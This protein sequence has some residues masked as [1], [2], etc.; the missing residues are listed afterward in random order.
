MWNDYLT[1]YSTW[2]G[3]V[4]INYFKQIIKIN[5]KATVF[6]LFHIYFTYIYI[7]DYSNLNHW[8]ELSYCYL[9]CIFIY[10]YFFLLEIFKKIIIFKMSLYDILLLLFVGKWFCCIVLDLKFLK[11]DVNLYSIAMKEFI[12][13]ILP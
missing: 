10:I 7:F 8:E 11:I 2:L 1:T 4:F 5:I 12:V 9:L 3:H 6:F 13:I